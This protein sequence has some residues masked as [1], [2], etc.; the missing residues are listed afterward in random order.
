MKDIFEGHKSL[1]FLHQKEIV[2]EENHAEHRACNIEESRVRQYKLDG[3]VIPRNKQRVCDYIVLNDDEKTAYLIELKGRH[4]EEAIEQIASSEKAVK[5]SLQGYDL[6]YRIV[7]HGRG[8]HKIA[9]A[10]LLAWREK[11]GKREKKW[12]AQFT[13][14]SYKETI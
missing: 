9:G 2:S 11:Y 10:R 3:D 7:Y 14:T 1:C 12:V 6:F 8:T 4:T 5:P 13:S